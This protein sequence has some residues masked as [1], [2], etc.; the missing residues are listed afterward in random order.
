MNQLSDPLALHFKLVRLRAEAAFVKRLNAGYGFADSSIPSQVFL[1]DNEARERLSRDAL[2]PKDPHEDQEDEI[3]VEIDEILTRLKGHDSPLFALANIF[4][5]SAIEQN[6]LTIAVSYGLNKD[7]SELCD[8]LSNSNR[9]QLRCEIIREILGGDEKY[10]HLM[11]VLHPRSTLVRESLI[12]FEMDASPV[13]GSFRANPRILYW[14][15]NV[16]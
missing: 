16:R 13:R 2:L 10:A 9:G 8:R 15:M 11:E 12:T 14:L 3:A 7:V 6:V 4:E 1:E 5:L